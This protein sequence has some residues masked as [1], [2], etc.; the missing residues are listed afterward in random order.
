MLLQASLGAAAAMAPGWANGG[1]DSSDEEGPAA[2]AVRE[3]E[4]QLD[5]AE[6]DALRS[7][8]DSVDEKDINQSETDAHRHSA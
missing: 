1:G 7:V 6:R 5:A 3:L 8:D 2:R 4:R